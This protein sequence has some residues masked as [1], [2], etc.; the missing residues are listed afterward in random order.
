MLKGELHFHTE[1]S[2]L[3][4]M[5]LAYRG[6]GY[7]FCIATNHNAVTDIPR[8]MK[9][10]RPIPICG[11]EHS[12]DLK[13]GRVHVS[14]FPCN[15]VFPEPPSVWKGLREIARRDPRS[16]AVVNH[17]LRGVKWT[18]GDV[19]RA[20]HNGVSILE[21]NP[22]GYD[23][24]EATRLWDAVLSRGIRMYGAISSDAHGVRDIDPFG[25]VLVDANSTASSIVEAI[26][27]GRFCAVDE[28]CVSRLLLFRVKE[29]G[30][31]GMILVRTL[32]ARSIRFVG[33]GGELLDYAMEQEACYSLT[34]D[35]TYVRAEVTDVNGK[36]I[37]TQPVFCDWSNPIS[38]HPFSVT[39]IPRGS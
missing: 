28:G 6:L 12:M 11:V 4:Q 23:I 20:A 36:A 17:P 16:V 33:D 3:D 2:T 27:A 15:W 24:E 5:I 32:A 1:R 7:D 9:R 18:V 10:R 26:A 34:G 31:G 29:G 35:E 37:Y 14:S 39:G 38:G 8:A 22:K 25:Y 30:S 19:A 21:L 13:A